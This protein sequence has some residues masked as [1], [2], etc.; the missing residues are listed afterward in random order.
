MQR[1]VQTT[2]DGLVE[3]GAE[4]G[5]QVADPTTGRPVAPDTVIYGF[6]AGKGMTATVAHLLVERGLLT[7]T[8][9]SP[10][11]GPRSARA[12]RGARPCATP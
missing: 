12:A 9:R 3:S 5:L 7:T 10:T 6:S 11:C 2:I 4:R 1:R 8:P